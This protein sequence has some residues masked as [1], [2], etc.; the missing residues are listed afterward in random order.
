MGR[1]SPKV[2]ARSRPDMRYW[3]IAILLLV[4]TV[5]ASCGG[6]SSTT[7][8]VVTPA[9]Q[10]S[11]PVI[12]SVAVSS[13][14]PTDFTV[15][16]NGSVFQS[17][18]QVMLNGTTSLTVISGTTAQIKTAALA[19]PLNSALSF[20][21]VNPDGGTSNSFAVPATSV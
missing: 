5:L 3:L 11:A 10:R 14:T 16:V 13:I 1:I 9:P 21:V 19:V 6:G 7:S 4:M 18:A 20:V 17:G 8:T 15:T 2:H 12:S